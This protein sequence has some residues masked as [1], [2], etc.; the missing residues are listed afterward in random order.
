MREKDGVFRVLRVVGRSG[1]SFV[2]AY[3]LFLAQESR[4]QEGIATLDKALA[5]EAK[6]EAM[7]LLWRNTL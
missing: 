5:K 7:P 4:G 3:L 6:R 1:F 2:D